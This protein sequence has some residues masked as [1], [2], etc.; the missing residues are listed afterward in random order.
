[1]IEY[2][3]IIIVACL[4]F[5][6]GVF[7]KKLVSSPISPPLFFCFTGIFLSTFSFEFAEDG[8]N[9]ELIRIFLELTLVITLFTDA[10]SINLKALKNFKSLI[11]KSLFF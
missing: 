5:I 9:T 1:M 2:P 4:I 8:F 6:Y 7:S 10:S 3:V 11:I